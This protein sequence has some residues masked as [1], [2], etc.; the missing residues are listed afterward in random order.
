MKKIIAVLLVI[1]ANAF[2]YDYSC[3]GIDD[4]GPY[5]I[6][7]FKLVTKDNATEISLDRFK[8][9]ETYAVAD[10][11]PQKPSKRPMITFSIQNAHYSQYGEGPVTPF[12]GDKELMS[13]GYELNSGKLGGFMKTAGIGYSW[14]KYLCV[15]NP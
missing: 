12:Y 14:A 15:R 6:K 4:N 3:F 8:F 5:G 1:S 7:K 10:H 9:T 2:A 11:T 13:G